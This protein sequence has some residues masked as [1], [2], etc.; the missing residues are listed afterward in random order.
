[1]AEIRR[2]GDNTGCMALKGAVPDHS[3]ADLPDRWRIADGQL[4]LAARW[5]IDPEVDLAK[6]RGQSSR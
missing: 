4:A 2:I 3:G 6:T 1:V 5:R